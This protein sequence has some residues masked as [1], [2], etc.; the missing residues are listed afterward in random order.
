[1]HYL[2]FCT[3]VYS[4]YVRIS[5]SDLYKKSEHILWFILYLYTQSLIALYRFFFYNQVIED[6]GTQSLKF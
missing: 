3:V 2:L 1:M 4:R 6:L 5:K